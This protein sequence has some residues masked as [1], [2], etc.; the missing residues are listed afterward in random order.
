MPNQFEHNA[1]KLKISVKR[2]L[3][4]CLTV[5]LS[6]PG[7]LLPPAPEAVSES[8]FTARLTGDRQLQVDLMLC[9]RR[10][11]CMVKRVDV[12]TGRLGGLRQ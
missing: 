2:N 6:L 11:P 7:T 9:S 12:T 10:I 5:A 1:V 3:Q 4:I 8:I